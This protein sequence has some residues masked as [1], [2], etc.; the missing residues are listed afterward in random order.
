MRIH[1]LPFLLRRS[2]TPTYPFLRVINFLR[3]GV[4]VRSAYAH[5]HGHGSCGGDGYAEGV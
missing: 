5:K 2:T 4:L 3:L 1:S